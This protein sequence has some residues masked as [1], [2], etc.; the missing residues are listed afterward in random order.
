MLTII[1]VLAVALVISA[2]VGYFWDDV[3]GAAKWAWEKIK[4]LWSIKGFLWT[5]LVKFLG[6]WQ[7]ALVKLV[8][9]FC[10]VFL[11]LVLWRVGSVTPSSSLSTPPTSTSGASG[12]TRPLATPTGT[13]TFTH[14]IVPSGPSGASGASG[15]SGPAIFSHGPA[16]VG[17]PIRTSSSFGLSPSGVEYIQ[18]QEEKRLK[19]QDTL[20]Q[21]AGATY[22]AALEKEVQAVAHQKSQSELARELTD[23][24]EGKKST[25]EVDDWA[26]AVNLASAGDPDLSPV[27]AVYQSYNALKSFVEDKEKFV[28]VEERNLP[29]PKAEITAEV[30]AR[31]I[32]YVTKIFSQVKAGKE[33]KCGLVEGEETFNYIGY[34]VFAMDYHKLTQAEAGVS[35]AEIKKMKIKELSRQMAQKGGWLEGIKGGDDDLRIK[36]NNTLN[37][38]NLL[39]K[40][41]YNS[42][43]C[44]LLDTIIEP[45]VIEEKDE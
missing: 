11:G 41:V 30:R 16:L 43:V 29:R 1:I 17:P 40:Q 37:N 32:A 13:I 35:P 45:K 44:K 14:P 23:L 27:C 21:A 6:G 36:V 2:L 34:A 4:L 15:A 22:H 33:I 10:F 24:L 20:A 42:S 31:A 25:P 5:Q 19:A 9:A 3:K 39:C 18:K 38:N 8:W 7:K 26:D 28:K 12:P